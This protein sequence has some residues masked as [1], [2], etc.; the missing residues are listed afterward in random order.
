MA[1]DDSGAV[2]LTPVPEAPSTTTEATTAISKVNKSLFR[3]RSSSS[4]AG[5]RL[6]CSS[7]SQLLLNL[8]Q[9]SLQGSNPRAETVCIPY[10]FVPGINIGSRTYQRAVQ[11]LTNPQHIRFASSTAERSKYLP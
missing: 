8:I 7:S 9:L 5:V 11:L 4:S 2:P 1:V 10:A 3:T 6:I